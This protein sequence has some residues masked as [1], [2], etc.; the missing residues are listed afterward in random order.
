MNDVRLH[1]PY[2]FGNKQNSKHTER[3]SDG[4]EIQK[5]AQLKTE[6]FG[7]ERPTVGQDRQKRGKTNSQ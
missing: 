4:R 3:E 1:V 6:K 5:K 7:Q 2:I